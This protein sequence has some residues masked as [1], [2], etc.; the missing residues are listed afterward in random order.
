MECFIAPY[1]LLKIRVQLFRWPKLVSMCLL[2]NGGKIVFNCVVKYVTHKYVGW[3]LYFKYTLW[4]PESILYYAYDWKLS[5]NQWKFT[6]Y[7]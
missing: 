4:Y 6:G 2:I 5:L 7:F 1:S 3:A